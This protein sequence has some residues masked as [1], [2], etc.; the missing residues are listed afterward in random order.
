MIDPP[1]CRC[2]SH[3]RHEDHPEVTSWVALDDLDFDWA[4]AL[5][6]AGPDRRYKGRR[7]PKDPPGGSGRGGKKDRCQSAPVQKNLNELMRCLHEHIVQQRAGE[8]ITS[9]EIIS[10]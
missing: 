6:Q 9:I 2:L 10:L 3:A 7:R 4:D 5:R 8:L 1:R